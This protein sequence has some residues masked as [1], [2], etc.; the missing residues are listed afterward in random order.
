MRKEELKGYCATKLGLDLNSKN[1]QEWWKKVGEFIRTKEDADS[2]I[3]AVKEDWFL[4]P[5]VHSHPGKVKKEIPLS[6]FPFSENHR[7]MIEAHSYALAYI[8]NSAPEV[9]GWRNQ[10]LKK[11]FLSPKEAVEF[12]HSPQNKGENLNSG[13]KI[14][15]DPDQVAFLLSP[16]QSPLGKLKK[17]VTGLLKDHPF[18]KP[19]NDEYIL[20]DYCWFILTGEVPFYGPIDVSSCIS[21]YTDPTIFPFGKSARFSSEYIEFRLAPW[22]PYKLIVKAYQ[23]AQ[24]DIFEGENRPLKK[25]TSMLMRVLFDY[26][27]TYNTLLP[28]WKE[29]MKIFNEK[30]TVLGVKKY[31]DERALRK[32]FLRGVSKLFGLKRQT[33]Q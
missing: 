12:L 6:K 20:F 2:E 15:G 21:F 18:F 23:R 27:I 19:L 10:Y 4:Y 22:L 25:R 16:P 32:D 33:G 3:R 30:A 7:N 31:S 9:Q 1:F 5:G 8:V 26:A 28:K 24:K 17:I 29:A 11:G 13:H 14:S